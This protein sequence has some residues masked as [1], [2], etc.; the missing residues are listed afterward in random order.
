MLRAL[1]LTLGLSALV[2]PMAL[3]EDVPDQLE[4][5]ALVAGRASEA[6][7]LDLAQT[8]DRLVAVGERGVIVTKEAGSVDWEQRVVPV[9]ATLTAVAFNPAGIG[10][11]VG[12]DGV[13]L[14]SPDRGVTWEKVSDGNR[15]FATVIAAAD[16]RYAA[17]ETALAAAT[18]DTRDD[19]QFALEDEE[20]RRETAQQSLEYGPSW[21]LL[22]VTFSEPNVAW[23]VGAYGT[24]FRSGDAGM[25]WELVADRVDN[26]EDLHLNAILKT[27]A[28]DL[29]IAGE[30]GMLFHSGDGGALFERF[31]SYDGLSLF[32]LVEADA[33]LLAYGFGD[34]AQISVD[35]GLT[36]EAVRFDDN[37]LL[38]GHVTLGP[39]RVGLLGGSGVMVEVTD[40][41]AQEITRP[42]GTR[43]FLSAGVQMGSGE[44]VFVGEDG[45]MPAE[46][47]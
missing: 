28:G 18:D 33:F 36:W 1:T 16:A 32:G 24:F 37:H 45:V 35:G 46:G 21:P 8:G 10:V 17:A 9:S 40:E 3:A 5:P 30:A 43:A 29:V 12:H 22:D 4:T 6:A 19:L 39:D 25:T 20:F 23:V 42:T 41:G 15:L 13:I 11:A 44:Q 27:S 34:S 38:I 26:F 47:K 14:R 2:A 7:L 31:D